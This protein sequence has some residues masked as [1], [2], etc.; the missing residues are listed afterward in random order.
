METE[1]IVRVILVEDQALYRSLLGDLIRREDGF[2]LVAA[3]GSV[4]EARML[5]ATRPVDVLLLDI[6]LPDGNGFALGR[7]LRTARPELG[8][9]LLSAHDMMDLL[10]ALPESDR[11]GWSYLSKVS[12]T[13]RQTLLRALR[14]SA[15]GGSMLDPDL[16]AGLT[17]RRGSALAELT[18]RQ[19]AA[20]RLLAQGLSNAA[21]ARE[22][23]I[24]AHSVDNLLNGVYT[25]LGVRDD[26]DLNS[27]V[28]AALH[29]V[30]DG[31][32]GAV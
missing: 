20:L 31:A 29:L 1:R 16:V 8:V 10:L 18:A 4:A 11:R 12:S 17:P 5:A 23:G 14:L 7:S 21:I 27:R 19:L 28:A 22:M 9:V 24:S 15:D 3:T 25:T 30:R 32:S 2:A 6:E 26:G 13:S